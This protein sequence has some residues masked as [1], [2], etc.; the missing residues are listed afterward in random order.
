MHQSIGN[1][2]KLLKKAADKKLPDALEKLGALYE[3]GRYVPR[4]LNVALSYYDQLIASGDDLALM[5]RARIHQKGLRGEKSEAKAID[6][7]EKA[8]ATGITAAKI[9]LALIYYNR[10]SKSKDLNK[11]LTLLKQAI[12]ARSSYA[13]LLFGLLYLKGEVHGEY[14]FQASPDSAISRVLNGP[15]SSIATLKRGISITADLCKQITETYPKGKPLSLSGHEYLIQQG[16]WKGAKDF[17]SYVNKLKADDS[18]RLNSKLSE[19]LDAFLDIAQ[20][21]IGYNEFSVLSSLNDLSNKIEG[22]ETDLIVPKSRNA[23]SVFH[24]I[25]PEAPP[26]QRSLM[27][28]K[29]IELFK[30]A[31]QEGSSSAAKF[32]LALMVRDGVGFAPDAG[33]AIELLKQSASQGYTAS[34]LVL[35]TMY[36]FGEGVAPDPEKAKK[37]YADAAERKDPLAYLHLGLMLE[38]GRDSDRDLEGA[39]KLYEMAA[40]EGITEAS[41]GLKRLIRDT[42]N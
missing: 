7:Y 27:I 10:D 39:R 26:D 28:A 6:F 29:A 3:E 34:M 15:H 17:V 9:E 2:L 31:V 24:D 12:D 33:K 25:N 23:S 38:F 4:D 5:V 1:G 22:I 16:I 14:S 40:S 20:T 41:D 19:A 42:D 13:M 35:G 32:N 8:A 36:H 37:Y 11:T 18:L 21:N 30:L